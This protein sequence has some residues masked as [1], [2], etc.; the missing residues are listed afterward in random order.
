MFCNMIY[1]CVNELWLDN[2]FMIFKMIEDDGYLVI[3]HGGAGF[4]DKGLMLPCGYICTCHEVWYEMICEK[5][6]QLNNVKLTVLACHE[7]ARSN[8]DDL[9]LVDFTPIG[10]SGVQCVSVY[11]SENEVVVW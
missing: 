7:E 9:P 11:K 5:Y 1:K 4:F 3:T 8:T 6:P 10:R 2:G